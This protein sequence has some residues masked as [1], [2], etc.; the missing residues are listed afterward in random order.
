M[1]TNFPVAT[2]I[3]ARF[4]ANFAAMGRRARAYGAVVA[5][6]DWG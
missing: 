4:H 6:G 1:L 5:G 2:D 3:T